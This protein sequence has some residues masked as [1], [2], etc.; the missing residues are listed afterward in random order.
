MDKKFSMI[1]DTLAVAILLGSIIF[2]SWLVLHDGNNINNQ[3]IDQIQIDVGEIK[4]ELPT[5]RMQVDR[6]SGDIQLLKHQ[7][8]NLNKQNEEAKKW[9]ENMIRIEEQNKQIAESLE[10]TNK[11]L[12]LLTERISKWEK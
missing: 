12:D 5:L 11:K 4:R 8:Q 9:R 2:T 3:K 6:N 1:K 7:V 10:R